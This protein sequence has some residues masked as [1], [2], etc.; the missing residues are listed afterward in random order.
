S[1]VVAISGFSFLTRSAQSNAAAEFAALKPWK[2]RGP[3]Q[4]A[5]RLVADLR[6]KL[7]A[8]P[9][10]IVLSFDPPSIPG[11]GTTGGFEFQVEDRT[12]RGVAALNEVTQAVIQEARKQPE[13]NGRSVFTTFSASTPQYLYDLDRTKAKLLGLTLPDVFST[14]Q[15]YLRSLYVSDFNLFGRTFRGT[16][17][18]QKDARADKGDISRL[19]VRNAT[20]GTVPVSTLG[21][22]KPT[23]GYDTVPHYNVYN[24]SLINGN[25]APGYSSGQGIQA[26]ERVAAQ[27]LPA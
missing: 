7:L 27:V 3:D 26:M 25:A 17:A 8:I 16:V 10:A 15:I 4:T 24:S 12:G 20:G 14:L 21:E 13:I 11:L 9:E 18:A 6:M 23:V 1:D 2:E 19:Y 22:L 5:S